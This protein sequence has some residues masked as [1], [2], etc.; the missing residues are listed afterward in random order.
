MVADMVCRRGRETA[1]RPRPPGYRCGDPTNGGCPCRRRS[2]PGA[3]ASGF[4]DAGVQGGKAHPAFRR[5]GLDRL[6]LLSRLS[7]HQ[8]VAAQDAIIPGLDIGRGWTVDIKIER[9][10]PFLAEKI[11]SSTISKA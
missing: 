3:G 11:L 4:C 10:N 7:A 9:F 6:Q 1:G 8:P 5:D 2:W